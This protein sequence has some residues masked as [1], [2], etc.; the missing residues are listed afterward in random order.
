MAERW[1]CYWK[2]W[3][4]VRFEYMCGRIA[5][6]RNLQAIL[7]CALRECLPEN[8]HIIIEPTWDVGGNKRSPDMVL[9][10]GGVITDIFELKYVPHHRPVFEYDIARLHAYVAGPGLPTY[11]VY[12]DPETGQWAD[13]LSIDK[14]CRLHF[15]AVGQHHA[16]AVN[17]SCLPGGNSINHWFGQVGNSPA[18]GIRR[19]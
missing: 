18:W 14:D 3:G 8:V 19:A 17:P 2:S 9:V 6:E 10:E 1:H 16:T 12:V 7:Y 11:P 15:V 4:Q 5:S 13:P